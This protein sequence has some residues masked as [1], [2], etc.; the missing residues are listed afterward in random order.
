MS[1][2][3]GGTNNHSTIISRRTIMKKLLFL[4]AILVLCLAFSQVFA[5]TR[6]LYASKGNLNDIINADTLANGTRLNDVY[7]LVSLDTTYKF[8]GTIESRKSISVIGVVQAS[9]KRPPCIQPAVLPDGTLPVT[10]FTLLGKQTT[11]TFKNL[12]LLALATNNTADA[13]GQA[14]QVSADKVKLVV[15]NCV[16]DGWLGFGIG[17]NGQ[18]DKFFI[19]K[20]TFRNFVHPNQWY[21]GEVIRNEWPG[22]AYTDTLSFKDCTSW[23]WRTA[24]S[25]DGWVSASG[26]TGSGTSSSSAKAISGIS[27]IRTSGTSEK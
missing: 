15:E 22:E 26:T 21:V 1:I 10:A 18:W 27:S 23:S 5:A 19:S 12:Y 14:F 13:A 25:T 3:N 2:E 6:I 8:S 17:Y 24:C 4:M 20:S 11:C 9:S 16:F 7:Q